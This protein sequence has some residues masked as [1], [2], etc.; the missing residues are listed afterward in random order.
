MGSEIRVR[1]GVKKKGE[2]LKKTVKSTKKTGSVSPFLGRIKILGR[3]W[4]FFGTQISA[5]KQQKNG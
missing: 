5:K 1:E 3:I 4:E 2:K